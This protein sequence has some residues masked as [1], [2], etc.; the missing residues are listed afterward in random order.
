MRKI[1]KLMLSALIVSLLTLALPLQAIAEDVSNVN[2]NKLISA[3][4][5]K[6]VS[7]TWFEKWAGA[8]GYQEIFSNGDG[9][10][11]PDQAITRMEFARMLHKA[12]GI[13]MNY[14][15]ATDIAEYYNDVKSSDKG[16]NELYDLVTCGIIDT[17]NSFRP[18]DTLSR[19]EMI[20]FIMNAF[21]H[22]AGSDYAI[23]EIY[24][25]FEDDKDIR[26]EYSTDI[27]HSCNLGLVN[28][29]SGNYL[30]PRDA[31][32]RAEAVTIAGKLAELLN[33]IESKVSV[34]AKAFEEDGALRM[35]LTVRNDS[36]K[37]LKIY[38]S[39][40]QLFDF[41]VFDKNGNSLYCWSADRMFAQVLSTTEIAPRKEIVFS[42][43]IGKETYSKFKDSMKTIVGYII[44]T[45]DDFKIDANGYSA[46]VPMPVG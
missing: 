16:A 8:Y 32:T 3:N 31:A 12:L 33:K 29:R 41:K 21:R 17:K 36:D 6:D 10:F 23:T 46:S 5:Y 15:A 30:F 39:S 40:Q 26:P 18:S 45:S 7:G 20:H 1:K 19:D 22:F 4:S 9:L 27:Q 42:D 14:F 11:S 38:H 35:T 13:N 25:L 43:T 24:R 2:D 28:G 34:Q 37:T 44:G